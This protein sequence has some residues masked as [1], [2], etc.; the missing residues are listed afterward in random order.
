MLD[1]T[2]F[3]EYINYWKTLAVAASGVPARGDFKPSHFPHLLPNF[4]ILERQG[5]IKSSV[6]LT[7]TA[8]DATSCFQY[9]PS[10]IFSRFKEKDWLLYN[11]YMDALFEYKCGAYGE[12]HYELANGLGFNACSVTFPFTGS[13]PAHRYVIGLMLVESKHQASLPEALP[14]DTRSKVTEF[15]YLDSGFGVPPK[16]DSLV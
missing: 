7:G 8:L 11:I 2:F 5:G 9:R 13:A 16:S 1:E 4:Y 12:R 14:L 10:D 3:N 6:R 15:T